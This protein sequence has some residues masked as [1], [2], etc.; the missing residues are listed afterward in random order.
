MLAKLSLGKT[1]YNS[2][3]NKCLFLLWMFSPR[4]VFTFFGYVHFVIIDVKMTTLNENLMEQINYITEEDVEHV[5]KS[6]GFRNNDIIIDNFVVNNASN[7]MLGF[8]ADYW[9]LQVVITTKSEK[10]VLSFFI[11]AVSRSNAAKAS[12]VKELN[13]FQKESTF[14][15]IIK[16]ALEVP[17]KFYSKSKYNNYL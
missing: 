7:K 4:H 1:N 14:Y 8:L 15:S 9:R 3:I 5:L 12:V 13:L 2:Y 16:T 11:K 6:C 17:G 10:Q